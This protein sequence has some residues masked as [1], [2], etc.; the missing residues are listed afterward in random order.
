MAD[1]HRIA[2]SKGGRSTLQ[3]YGRKHF[4]IIGSRGF[5][6]T[7]ARHW[8]GDKQSFREYLVARNWNRL[9]SALADQEIDRRLAN[10]E[11]I[12]CIELPY[13]DEEREFPF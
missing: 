3:R 5:Q 11:E 9:A 13:M 4:Q 8:A 1:H 2:G 6:V 7:V 10:G 12:A